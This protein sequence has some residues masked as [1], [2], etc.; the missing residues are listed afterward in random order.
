MRV[1]DASVWVSL[2]VP[3]D[4]NHAASRRWLHQYTT[5][6]G[7]L[8]EPILLMAE[9]T[10]AI[11]RR[12]GRP[13]LGRRALADILAFPALRLVSVDRRLGGTAA[14]LAADYRLRGAD[15]VYVALAQ[16]LAIPLVTWDVEQ[17]DRRQPVIQ[18][19]VPGTSF[20]T[21]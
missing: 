12:T 11:A 18:V 3:Q 5:D 15:A 8:V 14:Q 1:V 2:L 17:I 6:G 16:Q 9:V 20:T 10:G 19:G 7:V 4:M 21:A 13:E